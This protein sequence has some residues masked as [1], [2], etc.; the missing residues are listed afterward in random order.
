VVLP[1][2]SGFA[3]GGRLWWE[4]ATAVSVTLSLPNISLTD[5]PL[6]AVESLM[7]ADGSVM[8]VAA[9]LYPNSSMWLAYGWYIKNV[10]ARPQNYLW[11]LNA[12][13]PE[14]APGASVSLSISLSQHGWHYSI[15][16]MTS[17]AS[18]AGNY[19]F[20]VPPVLRVGDQEVFALESYST[21]NVVFANMGN[22][23]LNSLS[24]N[25]RQI[26][27]GWYVYGA[28]QNRHIPL[29]VVGSL[30]PPAYISLE[31]LKDSTFVWSYE[32]W[33]GNEGAPPSSTSLLGVLVVVPSVVLL[34]VVVW[35][36]TRRSS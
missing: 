36:A 2:G 22:L 3:D 11:V 33:S 23:T 5:Y 12:S 1:E 31:Q 21:S 14:M 28:W 7:A 26:A 34:S 35:V 10:L 8:Q 20:D 16:D 17:R 18:I 6:Y 30:D 32:E 15:E 24:I 25:G 9:G 13:Q 4:N 29:F 27:T 19:P